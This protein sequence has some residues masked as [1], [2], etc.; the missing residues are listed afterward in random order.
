[1]KIRTTVA[2]VGLAVAGILSVGAPAQA[3]T[4]D[5]CTAWNRYCQYVPTYRT[6]PIERCTAW[7]RYCRYV[8]TAWFRTNAGLR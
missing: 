1:M 4:I 3:V 7:N 6:T 2:G 8:P 5:R